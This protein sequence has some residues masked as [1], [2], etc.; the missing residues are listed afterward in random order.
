MLSFQLIS[1]S[2]LCVTIEMLHR[3]MHQDDK[4]NG[5][6]QETCSDYVTFDHMMKQLYQLYWLEIKSVSAQRITD[7]AIQTIGYS[8]C[9]Y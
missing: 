5:C 9:N 2:F 3:V 8:C 1:W 7:K 6:L 4:I